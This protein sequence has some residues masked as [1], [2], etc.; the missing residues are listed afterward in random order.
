MDGRKIGNFFDRNDTFS[1]QVPAFNMEGENVIGTLTGFILTVFFFLV[2]LSYGVFKF[3]HLYT[4]KNP[5]I[6][7]ILLSDEWSLEDAIDLH[8]ENA[9]FAFAIQD[10]YSREPK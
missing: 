7:T 10:F 6:T 3:I 1:V 8:E 5:L 9:V 4:K 2:I